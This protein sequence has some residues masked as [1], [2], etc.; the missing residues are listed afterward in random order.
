M[1]V[2]LLDEDAA[3]GE[4]LREIDRDWFTTVQPRGVMAGRSAIVL[5]SF[6]EDLEL[7]GLLQKTRP[8]AT[9]KD[10]IR[11]SRLVAISPPLSLDEVRAEMASNVRAHLDY[12]SLPEKT[13]EEALAAVARLRPDLADA[14]RALRPDRSARAR[15]S[16]AFGVVA[17]E[18]DAV[19]VALDISGVERAQLAR[20]RG[21]RQDAQPFLAGL[22]DAVLRED[23]MVVHDAGVFGD[24]EVVRRSA[25]GSVEF[26]SGGRSLTVINVNR[27]A[28]EKT[29]GVDLI[30]YHEFFH[31]FVLVQYKRMHKAGAGWLYRPDGNHDGEVERM[32]EIPALAADPPEPVKLGETL[33]GRI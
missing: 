28:I 4:Y 22:H 18:K 12:R 5:V 1:K 29:L 25:V 10:G 27:N 3:V 32:G 19:G 20:W 17:M 13:G 15:G 30:Y 11:C 9:Q 2:V 14:I 24:W 33:R 26:T 23:P 16:S 7:V 31:A 6:G 21:G 8:A